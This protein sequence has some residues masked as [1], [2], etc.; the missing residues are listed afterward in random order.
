[1]TTERAT[2]AGPSPATVAYIRPGQPQLPVGKPELV[3]DH[4]VLAFPVLCRGGEVGT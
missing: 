2:V 1:M 3:P 4:E